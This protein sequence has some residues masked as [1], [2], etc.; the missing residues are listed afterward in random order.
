MC[1]EVLICCGFHREK[2]GEELKH[3]NRGFDMLY[4][5]HRCI[6][7]FD[8]QKLGQPTINIFIRGFD[9]LCRIS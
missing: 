4:Y 7:V 1:Y 9:I 6:I 2:A 5:V 3:Y 8:T